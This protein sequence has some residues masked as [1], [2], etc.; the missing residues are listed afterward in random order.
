MYTMKTFYKKIFG[1]KATYSLKTIKDSQ[2]DMEQNKFETSITM[3]N[4]NPKKEVKEAFEQ[5]PII[6]A[7]IETSHL[8]NNCNIIENGILSLPSNENSQLSPLQFESTS[9][10]TQNKYDTIADSDGAKNGDTS[11]D[12]TVLNIKATSNVIRYSKKVDETQ[13]E[14]VP[15]ER[16]AT[17]IDA[18]KEVIII[19][20]N[21]LEQDILSQNGTLAIKNE[22]QSSSKKVARVKNELHNLSRE[23][24]QDFTPNEDQGS[25]IEQENRG[26]ED[27]LLGFHCETL[28]Y[29]RFP[30]VDE[31][32]ENSED[33]Q[34]SITITD[35]KIDIKGNNLSWPHDIA[36]NECSLL[37][38]D[39][40]NKNQVDSRIGLFSEKSGFQN[41]EESQPTFSN[42]DSTNDIM[43]INLSE[44][45]DTTSNETSKINE[46]ECS[47]EK[48]RINDIKLD[49]QIGLYSE[50]ADFQKDEDSQPHCD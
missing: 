17:I 36:N 25:S 29:F 7:K 43:D 3:E 32:T 47:L 15:K 46:N 31:G 38:K 2:N 26:C 33:S 18:D 39:E 8:D 13:C 41:V 6:D 34:P 4:E 45:L 49:S 37:E 21:C 48:N 44:P 35:S 24:K 12:Q 14:D 42:K 20:L 40:T 27:F 10:F 19:G 1:A 9:N 50:K 22:S 28:T 11:N 23:G 30:S 5:D 16:P